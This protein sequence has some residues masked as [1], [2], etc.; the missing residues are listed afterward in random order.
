M[1]EEKWKISSKKG[2]EALTSVRSAVRAWLSTQTACRSIA[3]V[4]Y[5]Q[6]VPA[7]GIGRKNEENA[8]GYHPLK[9]VK[10]S[11]KGSKISPV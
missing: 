11:S 6:L 8:C 2:K 1:A 9:A 10:S 5:I 4:Q 3:G 7:S